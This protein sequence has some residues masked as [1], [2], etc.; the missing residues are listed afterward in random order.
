MRNSALK[1]TQRLSA[2]S[3]VQELRGVC[4]SAPSVIVDT[5]KKPNCHNSLTVVLRLQMD[6]RA[7]VFEP[8][9]GMGTD[10]SAR[11]GVL[12]RWIREGFREDSRK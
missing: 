11:S 10:H 5:V 2:A 4:L 1:V 7:D 6:H 12:N 8:Q 9:R 3:V